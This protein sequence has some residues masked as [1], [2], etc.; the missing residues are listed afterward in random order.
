LLA[1]VKSFQKTVDKIQNQ[2]LQI[3]GEADDLSD[4]DL[5]GEPVCS[6]D[7]VTRIFLNAVMSVLYYD[8][9]VVV[10]AYSMI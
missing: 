3:F 4:D 8:C 5:N 7:T 6:V 9:F 2:K 1:E 10:C